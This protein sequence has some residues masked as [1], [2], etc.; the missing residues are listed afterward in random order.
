MR[1][2]FVGAIWTDIFRKWTKSKLNYGVPPTREKNSWVPHLACVLRIRHP[3]PHR[4]IVTHFEITLTNCQFFFFIFFYFHHRSGHKTKKKQVIN[5]RKNETPNKTQLIRVNEHVKKFTLVSDYTTI[6]SE[7][8][9]LL[10]IHNFYCFWFS[11][12]SV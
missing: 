7:K 11:R 12:P 8:D 6:N 2:G 3:C 4:S 1:E 10:H 5:S 9:F